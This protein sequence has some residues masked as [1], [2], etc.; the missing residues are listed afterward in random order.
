MVSIGQNIDFES[1][2]GVTPRP[3]ILKENNDE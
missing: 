3:I 2:I 1:E